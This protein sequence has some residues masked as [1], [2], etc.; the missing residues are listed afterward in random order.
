MNTNTIYFLAVTNP[1]TGQCWMGCVNDMYDTVQVY[2]VSDT[3]SFDC[4]AKH[5]KKWC[6]DYNLHY[7]CRTL[8]YTYQDI[9][10]APLDTVMYKLLA[11]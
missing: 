2:G 6:E 10:A 9:H 5:I 8:T 11:L 4:D 1:V 7:Q 3:Q